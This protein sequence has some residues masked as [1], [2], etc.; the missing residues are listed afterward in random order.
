MK[1]FLF[2]N[3][4]CFT[5]FLF[6]QNI[7]SQ[8]PDPNSFFPHSVGNIWEYDQGWYSSY[9]L[10][11]PNSNENS[12]SLNNTNEIVRF[13]IIRDSV[14]NNGQI[15]LFYGVGIFDP[16]WSIDTSARI[17]YYLPKRSNQ[18]YY[19]LEADIGSSWMVV[20]EDSSSGSQGKRALVT[21]RY[22]S[23]V[24]GILTEIMEIEYYEL[25]WGDTVINQYSTKIKTEKIAAGFG[26]LLRFYEEPGS[27]NRLL[28]GC[29][30]DGDTFG[31]IASVED[32]IKLP[33][34]FY[35]SQNSPNPFNPL[36]KIKYWLDSRQYVTL[37]VYDL[38][39]REVA[40]LVDAEKPA[41]V[42]EAIFD[43]SN[44]ACGVYIYCL[45]TNNDIVSKKM[46]LVK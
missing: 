10:M 7:F 31:I 12:A 43:G 4:A 22:P 18:Q 45:S 39:G 19:K 40:T 13:E 1:K 42:Y 21:N 24:F 6:T 26:L 27:F 5:I 30:I 35:L 16:L 41:G 25:N 34:D 9:K 23:I 44:L 14:G 29:V 46:T 20:Y 3:T 11:L 8:N 15:Y 32:I 33:K 2:I 38:L 17:V 37:K 28:L 36:T